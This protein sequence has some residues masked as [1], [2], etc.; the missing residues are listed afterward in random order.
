MGVPVNKVFHKRVVLPHRL[1]ATH[2]E[3]VKDRIFFVRVVVDFGNSVVALI[4]WKRTEKG[5]DSVVT[6]AGHLTAGPVP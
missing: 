3:R 2:D 4:E 6:A 1:V 5:I